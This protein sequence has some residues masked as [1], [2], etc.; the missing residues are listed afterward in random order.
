MIPKDLNEVNRWIGEDGWMDS[1]FLELKSLGK[2]DEAPTKGM[3]RK[4]MDQWL[5][6]INGLVIITCL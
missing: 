6:R 5:I 2:V 4:W 3:S 1:Q